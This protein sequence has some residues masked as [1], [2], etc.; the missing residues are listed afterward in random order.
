MNFTTKTALLSATL[1]LATLVN[2][3][4][5]SVKPN[6]VVQPLTANTATN[7]AQDLLLRADDDGSAYLYVEQQQGALLS[8]FDVTD[9]A[10]IKL[11]A[12]VETGTHGSYDFVRTIGTSELI[13][14]RDGSGSA[15]LD[16]RKARK[17]RLSMLNAPAASDTELLGNSGYLASSFETGN[18]RPQPIAAPAMSARSVQVVETQ[19]APRV[20]A[21]VPSVTRQ[22][23]RRDTGTTFLLGQN[24][25]TVVRQLDV[26]RNYA[27]QL[28]IW[29]SLN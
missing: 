20:L 12:S 13:A 25:V 17:P 1:A 9:P 16:L 4:N 23:A 19:S 6:L 28:A 18:Q 22:V 29:N 8:V 2:H 11:A 14:F 15:L 26:E 10:H 24:G 21:T 7:D 3:A 5:A 27:E